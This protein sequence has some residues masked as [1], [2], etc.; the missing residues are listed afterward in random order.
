MKRSAE[1][2]LN[3]DWGKQGKLFAHS[4]HCCYKDDLI[5]RDWGQ[6]AQKQLI[7]LLALLAACWVELLLGRCEKQWRC[8]KR[9]STK[10][11]HASPERLNQCP[12]GALKHLTHLLSDQTPGDKLGILTRTSA[13]EA[14]TVEPPELPAWASPRCV[15]FR[16]KTGTQ[17]PKNR[18]ASCQLSDFRLSWVYQGRWWVQGPRE[19]GLDDMIEGLLQFTST[20]WEL[21]SQVCQFLGSA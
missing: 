10:E 9:W 18:D 20:T 3:S 13:D 19:P 5:I 7:G 21:D 1:V 6:G 4:R 17:R 11:P 12:E 14:Y 16:A 8:E 15:H 2:C